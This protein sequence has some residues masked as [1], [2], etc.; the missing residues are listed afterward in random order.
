MLVIE[1]KNTG[2]I[3]QGDALDFIVDDEVMIGEIYLDGNLIFQ[4]DDVIDESFL[5]EEFKSQFEISSSTEALDDLDDEIY[6]ADYND[7]VY[8]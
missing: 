2:N 5:K 1:N 4:F 6:D 8:E 7:F 3:F